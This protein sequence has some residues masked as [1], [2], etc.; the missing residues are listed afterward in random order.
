MTWLK[1]VVKLYPKGSPSTYLLGDA[2]LVLNHRVN[3]K[4]FAAKPSLSGGDHKDIYMECLEMAGNIKRLVSKLRKIDKPYGAKGSHDP[5]IAELK[6]VLQKNA[7]YHRKDSTA[8]SPSVLELASP[9]LQESVSEQTSLVRQDSGDQATVPASLVCE[10]Q[11][12]QAT[13]NMER[14]PMTSQLLGALSQMSSDGLRSLCEVLQQYMRP[15]EDPALFVCSSPEG[16]LP[17]LDAPPLDAGIGH[18]WEVTRLCFDLPAWPTC[19]L[20][21]AHSFTFL[22]R[23]PGGFGYRLWHLLYAGYVQT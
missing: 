21:C 13:S 8:S 9:V 16:S 2:L 14:M 19:I 5:D 22:L 10:T 4:M 12:S 11:A 17:L 15:P 20:Y 18:A 3:F 7:A 6:G 1:T 23:C